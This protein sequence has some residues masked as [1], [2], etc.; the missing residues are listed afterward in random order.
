M[1]LEI[2]LRANDSLNTVVYSGLKDFS[3]GG[4]NTLTNFAYDTNSEAFSLNIGTYPS[5]DYVVHIISK[6]NGVLQ[7]EL[8]IYND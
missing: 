3:I 8:M 6:V 7:E 1:T 4:Q 5:L 2:E